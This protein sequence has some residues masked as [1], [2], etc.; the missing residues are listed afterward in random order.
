MV[1]VLGDREGG[2]DGR[3]D[4]EADVAQDQQTEATGNQQIG[5]A[6]MAA[7]A[8]EGQVGHEA[9]HDDGR[10]LDGHVQALVAVGETDVRQQRGRHDE[11]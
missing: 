3:V 6:M 11:A 10:G 5:A 7:V 1:D 8:A 9:A 2:I 4:D